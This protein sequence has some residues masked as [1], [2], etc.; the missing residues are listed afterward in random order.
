MRDELGFLALAPHT[1]ARAHHQ[2]GLFVRLAFRID[3]K[4]ARLR[5]E[6]GHLDLRHTAG[7]TL[8]FECLDLAFRQRIGD[9]AIRPSRTTDEHRARLLGRTQLQILAALRTGTHIRVGSHRIRERV[10]HF[11]LM[12]QKILEFLRQE[13]ARMANDLHLFAVAR[14]DL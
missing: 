8:L 12:R 6:R 3:A 1:S 2:V 11:F 7:R 13:I 4:N 5:T 9:I 10:A 14:C